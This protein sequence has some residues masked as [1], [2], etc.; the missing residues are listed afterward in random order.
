MLYT[1]NTSLS[2]GFSITKLVLSAILRA[3]TCLELLINQCQNNR[4]MA[5]CQKWRKEECRMWMVWP[6]MWQNGQPQTLVQKVLEIQWDSQ[7]DIAQHYEFLF[8]ILSSRFVFIIPWRPADDV[9]E[10]SVSH[11]PGNITFNTSLK[12]HGHFIPN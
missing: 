11:L 8:Q 4:E 5:G 12:L 3:L 1:Q 9:T 10:Y 7:A 2:T 6:I